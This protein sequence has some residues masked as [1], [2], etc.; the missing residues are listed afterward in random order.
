M[1]EKFYGKKEKMCCYVACWGARKQIIC[2]N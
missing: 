2:F 1:K